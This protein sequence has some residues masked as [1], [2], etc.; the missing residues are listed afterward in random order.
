MPHETALIATIAAGIGLA[1]ILGLGAGRGVVCVRRV[2]VFR[3]PV[4]A[5][6][7]ISARLAQVG[8]F[9]FILA[10]LGMSLGLL[11]AEGQASSFP[12]PSPPSA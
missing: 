8:E 5:A 4:H 10:A 9:S 2:L 11:P 6:A 7:T 1:F 3:C 12:A